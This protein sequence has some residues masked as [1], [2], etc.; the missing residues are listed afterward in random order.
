V[1]PFHIA[2][3]LAG[4]Q[5]RK[6][7]WTDERTKWNGKNRT[8]EWGSKWLREQRSRCWQRERGRAQSQLDISISPLRWRSALMLFLLALSR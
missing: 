8:F 1:L 7:M 6:W 4:H 3:P 2:L 5:K